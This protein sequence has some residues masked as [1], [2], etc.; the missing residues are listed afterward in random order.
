MK[1]ISCPKLNLIEAVHRYKRVLGEP[2]FLSTNK[3]PNHPA[4]RQ[5]GGYGLGLGSSS[6]LSHRGAVASDR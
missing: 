4:E 3:I 2:E 1:T 6:D 5:L